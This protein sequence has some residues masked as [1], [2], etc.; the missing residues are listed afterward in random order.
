MASVPSIDRQ[1]ASTVFRS[2]ENT[3][4]QEALPVVEDRLREVLTGEE[5]LPDV[6]LLAT[7][8]GRFRV[9]GTQRLTAADNAHDEELAND[10]EP[11]QR[12]DV[13]GERVHGK[14]VHVRRIA[15]GLFGPERSGEVLGTSGPTAPVTEGERLWRQAE[16]TA[17]RLEAPGF[18]AQAT[19]TSSVQ[20]DPAQ[21]AA[22]LRSDNA[23]F[24]EALDAVALEQRRAE[25]SLQAKDA[26]L[27]EATRIDA[28]CAR[29]YVG[30]FLLAD[31]RD[32]AA[33]F[34][35]ALRRTR[36]RA[37]SAGDP[38]PLP[39]SGP[40]PDGEPSPAASSAD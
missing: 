17:N 39:D 1:K 13:A 29:I 35:R 37:S 7:L 6:R 15:D 22:E 38:S 2:V 21:L 18:T 32:L 26:R 4:V 24:R 40:S 36:R 30:L 25:A 31:R 12:R 5:T 8:L 3:H 23:A 9:G 33:R 16:D 34:L 14:L 10:N 27:T 20:F 28:A 19:T 11:R